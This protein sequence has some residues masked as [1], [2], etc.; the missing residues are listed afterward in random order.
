MST[1]NQD[2]HVHNMRIPST[3][4]ARMSE[5]PMAHLQYYCDNISIN[6]LGLRHHSDDIHTSVIFSLACLSPASRIDHCVRAFLITTDWVSQI[7]IK[8]API[9]FLF[10]HSSLKRL[11][12]PG[13]AILYA[14]AD[15]VLITNRL[16]AISFGI[17]SSR[18]IECYGGDSCFT[19][20]SKWSTQHVPTLLEIH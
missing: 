19:F 20:Q 6:S 16:A 18:I 7:I 10:F 15:R 14:T 13:T 1:P 11:V 8:F 2:N 3:C 5:R 12:D 17:I 9:A 4:P